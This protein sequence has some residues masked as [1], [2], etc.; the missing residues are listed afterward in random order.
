MRHLL[1]VREFYA[2]RLYSVCNPFF[3]SLKSKLK[4]NCCF[5]ETKRNYQVWLFPV[6]IVYLGNLGPADNF[7][8]KKVETSPCGWFKSMCIWHILFGIRLWTNSNCPHMNLTGLSSISIT[9]I[10]CWQIITVHILDLGFRKMVFC[11]KNCFYLL[12]EK[13]ALVIEK[14]F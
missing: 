12:R 14:N 5:D 13:I 9:Y 11:F 6:C 10:L 7:Q 4:R 2:K 1:I 8:I 3:K